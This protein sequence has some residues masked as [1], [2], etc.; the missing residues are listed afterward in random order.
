MQPHNSELIWAQFISCKGNGLKKNLPA[1]A[2]MENGI[3][4]E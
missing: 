3:T 2:E 4:C 1:S